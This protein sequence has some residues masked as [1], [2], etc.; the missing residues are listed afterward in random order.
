MEHWI[1]EYYEYIKWL[2][3]VAIISWMASIFYLPRL[4]VYHTEVEVGSSSDVLFQKMER[5]LLRIIMNPAM[6]ASIITGILLVYSIGLTGNRW[7]HFKLLLVMIML[8]LHGTLARYRK[9]F[10]AGRN[11]HSAY[12]FRILNEV[13]PVLMIVITFLVIIK[14]F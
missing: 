13:P 10:A 6:V 2:H 12:Y 9:L 1:G 5:R 14:P 8:G 7:L 3:L 4:Y 11:L